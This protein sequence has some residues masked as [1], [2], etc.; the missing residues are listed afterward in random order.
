MG[1]SFAVFS[2]RHCIRVIYVVVTLTE[3]YYL[4]VAG[5][6]Q[7]ATLRAIYDIIFHMFIDSKTCF[8]AIGVNMD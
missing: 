1:S 5:G 8:N 4:N 2:G 3:E 7:Y 6:V